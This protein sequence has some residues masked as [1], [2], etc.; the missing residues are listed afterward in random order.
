MN[1]NELNNQ[2]FT[3]F[4]VD[5]M[6]ASLEAGELIVTV[7]EDESTLTQDEI[8]YVQGELAAKKYIMTHPDDKSYHDH[9]C[10][11]EAYENGYHDTRAV[12]L[13]TQ[14]TN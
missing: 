10:S 8:E 1:A 5:A 13:R 6:I 14:Q 7:L 9:I 2:E 11:S 12:W 4:D 3:E